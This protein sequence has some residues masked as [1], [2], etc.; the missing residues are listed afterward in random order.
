MNKNIAFILVAVCLVIAVVAGVNILSSNQINKNKSISDSTE[1]IITPIYISPTPKNQEV[2]PLPTEEDII[3]AFFNLINEKRIPEAISMMAPSAI[4]NESG[5]QAWGVQFNAF[6]SVLVDK[7][8]S[9]MK[10]EWTGDNHS[11]KVEL[12]VSMKPEAAKAVIPD[13]GYDNGKNIR[14]IS[15]VRV[16]NLWKIQGIATGP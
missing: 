8:S 16:A 4:G 12:T 3:R 5:K 11:Y 2:V 9:S 1:R 7:V 6:E 15:I 13:Y 10:E 14:W